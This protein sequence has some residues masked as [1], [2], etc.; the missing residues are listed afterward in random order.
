MMFIIETFRALAH[1]HGHL[2]VCT[3]HNNKRRLSF[4]L[5]HSRFSDM[6]DNERAAFFWRPH[7]DAAHFLLVGVIGRYMCEFGRFKGAAAH[8]ILACLSPSTAQPRTLISRLPLHTPERVA[9]D[10]RGRGGAPAG[11]QPGTRG[12]GRA[13]EECELGDGREPAGPVGGDAAH[14]PGPLRCVP[15]V[16]SAFSRTKHTNIINNVAKNK[17]RTTG[18][19]W[20]IVAASVVESAVALRHGPLTPLSAQELLDW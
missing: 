16:Y 7:A 10:D 12:K 4:S 13:P 8:D 20:S 6:S 11:G 1:S 18:G 15:V 14:Q 3:D 19:C 9:A 5:R 17:Q 2:F